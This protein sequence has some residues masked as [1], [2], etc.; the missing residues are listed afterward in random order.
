MT[1]ESKSVEADLKAAARRFCTV[2]NTDLL[3][4]YFRCDQESK[5]FLDFPDGKVISELFAEYKPQNENIT[6]LLQMKGGVFQVAIGLMKALRASYKGNIR[7]V[8]QSVSKSSGSF[9]ALSSCDCFLHP[10]AVISNFSIDKS[11]YE[12]PQRIPG[13][14]HDG[15]ELFLQGKKPTSFA[16]T[17]VHMNKF[18]SLIT[19]SEHAFD[20]TYD[21]ASD[22]HG[23]R[24]LKE[25]GVHTSHLQGLHTGLLH[26]F[27]HDPSI[28]KIVGF[29]DNFLAID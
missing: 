2:E 14:Y 9:I 24:H 7:A 11:M 21:Q 16:D 1:S 23:V 3:T 4:L 20:I 12:Q 18:R 15:L 19:A 22:S 27:N 8:I 17:L 28:L 5:T 13:Y 26:E 10:K 25:F 6:L 29:H